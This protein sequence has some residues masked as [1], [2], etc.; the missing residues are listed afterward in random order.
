MKVLN[1]QLKTKKLTQPIQPFLGELMSA[2]TLKWSQNVA[3]SICMIYCVETTNL[4]QIDRK[5]KTKNQIHPTTIMVNKEWFSTYE[6]EH[7]NL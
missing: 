1:F 3:D 4:L 7:V 6:F 2:Q 5:V